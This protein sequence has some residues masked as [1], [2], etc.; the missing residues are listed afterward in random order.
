MA[1]IFSIEGLKEKASSWFHRSKERVLSGR[2]LFTKKYYKNLYY[3]FRGELG[4]F[5]SVQLIAV[6]VAFGLFMILPL[7]SVIGTA[8][9]INGRFSLIWF[10]LI[11]SDPRF[12]PVSGISGVPIERIGDYLYIRGV[13][14]GAILNSVYVGLLTTAISTFIGV[15]LAFF[16]A[17]YEFRGKSILRVLLLIPL[18][19]TPFVSAIAIKKIFGEFGMLNL[20][21]YPLTG[22]RVIIEGLAAVIFVQSF[23]FFS[24][25]YLSTY[26]A[27]LAID[28]S[29]EE[30]G[31]N[32][33]AKGFGLF[34]RV[35]LPLALPGIEAGAILTF[36]LSVEDLGTLIVFSE[37]SQV[38]RTITYQIYSLIFA[39]TGAINP[40]APALSVILLLIAMIGFLLI[41]RYM[42]LRQYAMQTKG[43]TWNPRLHKTK[44]YQYIAIFVFTG[45]VLFF[46]LLTPVGIILLAFSTEWGTTILPINF[47]TTI[48]FF[49]VFTDP[50][51]VNSFINS[52]VYSGVAVGI[53][54]VLATGVAY[55]VAR[56]KLPGMP[57]LDLM[58][59]I[60]IA[61]PGIVIAMGYFLFFVRTPIFTNTILNPLITTVVL[62]TMAFAVRKFPFTVRSTYAGLQQT[63]VELEEAALNLGASRAR[64]FA[65]IVI[66][67]V[68]VSVLAGGMMSFV[69][70][71]SE[72]SVSLVL[73]GVQPLEAPLTWKMAD[74]LSQVAAGSHSAAVLGFLLMVIQIII[75]TIVNVVLKRRT[76][77]MVGL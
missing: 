45:V 33:G 69:Y 5:S 8:F 57:G 73:G 37:V 56:K 29:L 53:I 67:L 18:L 59:T 71:M 25:V 20:I 14:C 23:H 26:G 34:R 2:Q 64:T 27:F 43:G 10:Q 12:W 61:L 31:E 39:P 40:I 21:F 66:P 52:L 51:V 36:I 50:L 28:P 24:L 16:M 22:V 1:S 72:V 54:V 7:M 3:Q 65:G 44:W 76:E 68:A 48:N 17:R 46:A 6:I 70:C 15:T 41:R 42:S 32:M 35:T 30:Q 74:I 13:D 11:F 9:V 47:P 58:V 63:N 77:A 60:P 55:I 4:L 19:S 49:L 38:R 62:F 75:I